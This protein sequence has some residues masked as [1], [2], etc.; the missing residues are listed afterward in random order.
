MKTEQKLTFFFFLE[1]QKLNGQLSHSFRNQIFRGQHVRVFNQ[2]LKECDN[3]E[4]IACRYFLII[5]KRVPI[6]MKDRNS[7]CV[8]FS[9][10][11]F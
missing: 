5:E 3:S 9:K 7:L 11:S 6:A 2:I 1:E 4:S 10:F 8:K